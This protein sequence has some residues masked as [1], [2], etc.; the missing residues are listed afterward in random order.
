PPT[1]E[2]YPDPPRTHVSVDGASSAM[3]GAHRPGHFAGVAT[4]VAKLFAGIGP[5]VAVFGR[6]DAQQVAVVRRMTFDL[7]FPVEIVAA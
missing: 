4:V 2:M 6:K 5:A 3:E 1:E 7:S